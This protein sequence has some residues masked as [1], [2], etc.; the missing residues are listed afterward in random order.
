MKMKLV[1]IKMES[2]EI[3][4]KNNIDGSCIKANI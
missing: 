4:W 3:K 2:V 1:I